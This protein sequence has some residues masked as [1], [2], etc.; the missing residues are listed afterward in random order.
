MSATDRR[1]RGY[2]PRFDIDYAAGHEGETFVYRIVEGIR[3][4]SI[5]VKTDEKTPETQNVYIEYECKKHGEWVPSGI[6]ATEAQSWAICLGGGVMVA[7]SVEVLRDIAR[8]HYAMRTHRASCM[9][10][11]HPTRGVIIPVRD[12]LWQ[13][14]L[15]AEQDRSG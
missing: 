15:R 1:S 12:L 14:L 11:S 6:K 2:E 7:T 5:E 9:R 10:G 3:D 13:L 8:Q 4:G